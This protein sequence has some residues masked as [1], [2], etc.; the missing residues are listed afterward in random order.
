MSHDHEAQQNKAVNLEVHQEIFDDRLTII[1]KKQAEDGLS[2]P[3]Q[4][5]LV[6]NVR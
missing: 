2:V 6:E 1:K 5:F 3:L 4:E